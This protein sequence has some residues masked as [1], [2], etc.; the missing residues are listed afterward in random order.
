MTSGIESA[1]EDA[2]AIGRA[3]VWTIELAR[4]HCLNM[5]FTKWEGGG[6]G[7]AEQLSGLPIDTRRVSCPI[8][9]GNS[10]AMNLDWV[11]SDFYDEHCVGCQ[12]RRPTG[13][14]PNLASVME[15]RKAA[16]APRQ[17]A[18]LQNGDT[19]TGSCALNAA[20]RL[21]PARTRPCRAFCTISGC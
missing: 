9:R 18:W 19:A 6:Q 4:R 3:N 14:L 12:H 15:E 13:E 21:P 1:F 8:A 17:S 10:A 2:Y 11:A 5:T 7:M 16:A 20:V